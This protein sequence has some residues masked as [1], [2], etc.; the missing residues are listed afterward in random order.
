MIRER[1]AAVGAV[2]AAFATCLCCLG[3]LVAVGLGLGAYGAALEPLRPYLLVASAVALGFGFRRVYV[4]SSEV[5]G[6][7]GQCGP[8]RSNGMTRMVLWLAATL[9]LALGVAPYAADPRRVAFTEATSQ[10][11]YGATAEGAATAIAK[12]TLAVSGMT[13]ASCETTVC[14]ALEGTPGVISASV[15]Y[16]SGEALISYDPARTTP[17]EVSQ[18]ITRETGYETTPR[19]TR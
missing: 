19:E 7:D 12:S 16:K 13:C 10:S 5:C 14:L 4:Q 9:V 3:P 17:A 15:S 8:E 1:I 2:A 6:L 18:A 11:A